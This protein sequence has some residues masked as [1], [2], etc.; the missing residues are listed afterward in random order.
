MQAQGCEIHTMFP[1]KFPQFSHQ[2]VVILKTYASSR[3]NYLPA[4]S[5]T[6]LAIP[7][8]QMVLMG[9]KQ[10]KSYTSLGKLLKKETAD[11]RKQ[12]SPSKLTSI[13]HAL[14]CQCTNWERPFYQTGTWKLLLNKHLIDL[15]HLEMEKFYNQWLIF[16][17][18][19]GSHNLGKKPK[20]GTCTCSHCLALRWAGNSLST[21]LV[22][23]SKENNEKF[24]FPDSVFLWVFFKLLFLGS[25]PSHSLSRLSNS[26]PC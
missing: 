17:V 14:P 23:G 1:C 4:S 20:N 19:P 10:W 13:I 16:K 21:E 6:Y 12:Q 2:H 11:Y 7:L 25:S 18:I 15:L 3:T 5:G 9:T 24:L 22:A 26:N 8:Q